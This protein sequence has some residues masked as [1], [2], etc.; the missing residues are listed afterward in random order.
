MGLNKLNYDQLGDWRRC[1]KMNVC[2]GFGDLRNTYRAIM[3]GQTCGRFSG[4]RG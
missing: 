4:Y 2:H 1:W 3:A